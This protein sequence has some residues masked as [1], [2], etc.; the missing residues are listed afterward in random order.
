MTTDQFESILRPLAEEFATKV[1]VAVSQHLRERVG[2]EVQAVVE[3][4]FGG[5]VPAPPS[6]APAAPA[7]APAATAAMARS[8]RATRPKTRRRNARTTKAARAAVRCSRKGC[9]G[10]WYRPSGSAKKLC[11]QHF[12]EAGGKAPPGKKP[13]AGKKTKKR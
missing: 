10:S 2:A 4:A 8:A 5:A 7:A 9:T 1:A 11:Y 3:R 12:L 6:A 13:G